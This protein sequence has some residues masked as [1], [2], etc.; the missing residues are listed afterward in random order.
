MV[1]LPGNSLANAE[2]A[3]SLLDDQ[4]VRGGWMPGGPPD[5]WPG[6][7]LPE[8]CQAEPSWREAL[9]AGILARWP[10][11]DASARF[12]LIKLLEGNELRGPDTMAGVLGLMGGEA[13]GTE[14]ALQLLNT[15]VT[16]CRDLEGHT[17]I[18]ARARAL[19]GDHPAVG[20]VLARLHW[21]R[22]RP[23]LAECLQRCTAK[24]INMASAGFAT[25]TSRAREAVELCIGLDQATRAAFTGHMQV[26]LL[27]HGK[28]DKGLAKIIRKHWRLG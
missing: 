3:L 28:R 17:E 6:A 14:D 18:Y 22:A 21:Q 4:L 1:E 7:W 10:S 5:A 26:V 16:L 20:F 19:L 25:A 8:V 15:A 24:E 27:L 9:V 13:R 12:V 2:D 23:L 11:G